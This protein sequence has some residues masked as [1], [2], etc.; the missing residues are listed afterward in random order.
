[1]PF[2]YLQGRSHGRPFAPM[3]GSHG[4]NDHRWLEESVE[5]GSACP[6]VLLYSTESWQTAGDRFVRE[7]L[8]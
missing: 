2:E 6:M 4:R 5:A 1:M 3:G 8:T 7:S